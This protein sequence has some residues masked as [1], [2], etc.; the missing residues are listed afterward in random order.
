MNILEVPSR[1]NHQVHYLIESENHPLAKASEN[2]PEG[3]RRL[4]L[5]EGS[6]LI[7]TLD[8]G[9]PLLL[10]MARD[11]LTSWMSDCLH[12]EPTDSYKISSL[13]MELFLSRQGIKTESYRIHKVRNNR[14]VQV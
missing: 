6:T 3:S 13:D 10:Q 4:K 11:E 8:L 12:E 9:T 1:S 5:N 2:L 7:Q 14:L